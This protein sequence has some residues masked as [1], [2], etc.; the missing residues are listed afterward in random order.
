MKP[1]TGTMGVSETSDDDEDAG[2][3]EQLD[4]IGRAVT[5]QATGESGGA[6]EPRTDQ[7]EV[8]DEV[9]PARV[10]A[11]LFQQ[12]AE[13]QE[14]GRYA[15]LG[16]LGQGG[17]GVVLRAYDR[18]LDR[19]VA[20]KV[21][22]RELDAE[23]TTRL[24]REAQAMAKLSHPNVV[25]VY[26]VSEIA[27]Q[28]FVAMELVKGKTVHE[29][30]QEE[31]RPDWRACVRL[32][33][34]LGAGL[35][36]AHER[37]LIHRDFKPGNAIIDEKG[38]PRVLDFGLA[39]QHEA[40]DEAGEPSIAIPHAPTMEHEL[41]PREEPLTR[42]GTVL[43][44]LAYMPLEQMLGL[45]TDA[46]SDQFSFCVSLYEAVYG[47]RPF[48]GT[49]TMALM[50]SMHSGAVRPP[51]KGSKVP[52]A[53]RKLLIRGLATTP[54][55]RWPSMEALLEQLRSLVTPCGGRSI[56]LAVGVG[57]LAIAGGLGV[58]RFAEWSNRCTGARAQL[59]GIW[60]DTRR[61]AVKAAILGTELSYA[62]GTWERVEQRLDDYTE[63]WV[64]EHTE[65]CEA[66]AVRKEQSTETMDLRMGCLLEQRSHLQATVDVLAGA[67]AKVVEN[68]VQ[69]VAS[70]PRLERCAD[71]DALAAEVPP[72]ED[73]TVAERVAELDEQ[74]VV[75]KAA[76]VAGRY[77]ESLA[78]V[79]AVATEAETLDYEPLMARA[80]LR[81]G[82]L[83]TETGDYEGA[84]TTLRRAYDA[85]M[86]RRMTAEAASASAK[87]VYTLDMLARHEE[88]GYW[89]AN[90]DPLSR[91]ARTDEARALYL[92]NLGALMASQGKLDE[93]RVLF[94]RTLAIRE[95]ALGPEHLD[96]AASRGNLGNVAAAQG[97]LDEA[98]DSFERALAIREQ[99]LGPEHPAV[100]QTLNS[101]GGVAKLQG[102]LDEA[103]GFIERALAIRERA[104]GA[105]HPAVADA[106]NNLGNVALEQGK[107][108]EAR[109]CFE[110]A[111]AILEKKLGPE[112]PN[113]A[114]SLNNLGAVAS[115]QGKLDEARASCER[116]LAIWEKAHGPEHPDV[117]RAL[118]NLGNVAR[119]QGRLD[120]ARD[121]FVRTLAIQQKA[122]GPDHPAVG[123][124]FHDLGAVA[125]LQGE[126]DEA[127][128]SFERAL[129][130]E[131]KALGP[132]HL[133]VA[134]PLTGL[135]QVLL[136]LA[137]PAEALPHLERAL[138]IRTAHEADPAL[139][140]ETRFA[141]AR[142]LWSVPATHGRDRG[143]EL[144]EQA[145]DVWARA[146][147]GDEP[148]LAEVDQWLA[149]HRVQGDLGR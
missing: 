90:A 33:V 58:D 92:D 60:D 69:A 142:A 135:G 17:M 125:R 7:S 54:A 55:Q 35:A 81:Q 134:Y 122:R 36:A 101:L 46:R 48:E 20:L 49:S 130:I 100:A 138:A 43:G 76:Q 132:E 86:A 50:V 93:A 149:E 45:E 14:L 94:E 57:L 95:Q 63:A 1:T 82:W 59:D 144:A 147:T 146:D 70:L 88:A 123:V 109:D 6:P 51:P 78:V 110:R 2:R 143:L 71:V 117:A 65:V 111:R 99:A 30:M 129:A 37:G 87:L 28:T 29:W 139:I 145:R 148:R 27:G 128:G 5:L 56:A 85:A 131:E 73:P 68:A 104:L 13:P 136:G 18:Q 25:Q 40:N 38:R 133:L 61:Q 62:T 102:K 80:W 8:G 74:L 107:L 75:A 98:R 64:R 16:T 47:E 32:F 22:R 41:A 113:L 97:K 118:G 19:P 11:T 23:H 15:V 39:R 3:T 140:A 112:H 124:A 77:D 21:L 67:N 141:L 9:D 79:V 44:T 106:L 96:V 10:L 120:E 119:L 31:P 116:A 26:E 91:A 127:R 103:R 89:T 52:A 24:R 121:L 72:P 12:A 34:Q 114:Y 115:L 66:T 42:A 137:E 53:L 108:D 105:E 83:R 4:D 126:L 84:V